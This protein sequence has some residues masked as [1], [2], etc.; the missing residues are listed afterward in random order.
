LYRISEHE[1]HGSGQTH[2]RHQM[3]SALKFIEEEEG[4]IRDNLLSRLA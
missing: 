2:A 3:I 1:P 4:E